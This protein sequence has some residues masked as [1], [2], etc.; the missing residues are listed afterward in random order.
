MVALNEPS[1][2][3]EKK[4]SIRN[5][6]IDTAQPSLELQEESDGRNSPVPVMVAFK[7]FQP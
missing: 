7:E 5:I 1:V 4:D 6:H 3:I 2:F